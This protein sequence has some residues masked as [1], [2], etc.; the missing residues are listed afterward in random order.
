[1]SSRDAK[2]L[3]PRLDLP[4]EPKMNQQKPPAEIDGAKVLEWAW[5][6]EVP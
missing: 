5:S 6:G 4:P 3:E 1:M 2:L